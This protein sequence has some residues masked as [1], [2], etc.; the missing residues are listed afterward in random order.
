M[1]VMFTPDSQNYTVPTDPNMFANY[2]P[3]L[4]VYF[5]PTLQI[6][7]SWLWHYIGVWA[8]SHPE[9]TSLMI[10]MK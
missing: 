10:V 2:S 4:F 9:V 8:L 6:N 3:I 1:A 7:A 5:D